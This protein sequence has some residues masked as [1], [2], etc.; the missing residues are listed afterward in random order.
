MLNIAIVDDNIE[1]IADI[2]RFLG[3]SIK[4][5]EYEAYKYSDE[6][7]FMNDIKEGARYDIVFLDIMLSQS[8][9]IDV[10]EVILEHWART[11]IIFVSANSEYFKDVYNVEHTCFLTKP[12]E[13][14]RFLKALKKAIDSLYNSFIN[15]PLKSGLRR[16]ELNTLLYIENNLKATTFYFDGGWR[17]YFPIRL[18]DIE[19]MLPK[20]TFVRTHQS[21][22]INVEKHVSV[23]RLQVQMQNGAVI[24]ISKKYIND[25]RDKV[26]LYLGGVL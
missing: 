22:I 7:A 20:N 15:L 16:I 13:P 17:E 5:T 3:Q 18:A 21:Y 6:I 25:V 1:F 14:I 9:G 4:L 11:K 23:E 10:G 8:S 2:D 19:G 26:S 12:I 24:P